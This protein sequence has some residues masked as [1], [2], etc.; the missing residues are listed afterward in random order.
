MPHNSLKIV[1]IRGMLG[2]VL[3]ENKKN[4]LLISSNGHRGKWILPAGT[5]EL[6]KLSRYSYTK[7]NECEPAIKEQSR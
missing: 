7:V 4:I 2:V 3:S 1:V 5:L 6:S